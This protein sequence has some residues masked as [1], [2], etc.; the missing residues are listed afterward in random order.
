MIAE[1]VISDMKMGLDPKQYGNQ[2]NTSIQH[3]LLGLL[4]RIVTSV[5]KNSKGEIN[6]VL[7]SFVDWKSAFSKQC[8][9]LGI[10]SFLRN[11]VRPSLIPL[12]ISY[13]QNRQMRVKHHGKVSKSRKMPGSGAQGAT[14]GNWEF[15]SQTNNNSDCVPEE[16]RFKF[17]DDLTILEIINLINI[18]LSSYN[19]RDHVASDISIN[20]H[21]VDKEHLL[22][23][24]YINTIN[25]WTEKQKMEISSKKTKAMIINFTDN[26]QF[27]TRLQ[28][29]NRN[30]E[31]VDQMKILGTIVTNK[32]S[33]QENCSYLIQRVN[34][35]MLLLK[36]ALSFGA[37][38]EEM[39]HLW[40]I[41]CRSVLEQSAIVWSSSLNED[42][43]AD[44]ERT[45]K[46]FAKMVLK[47][48]YK[49][50]E[51]ALLELNLEKLEK[52]RSDLELTFAKKCIKNGKLSNL[53]Q[54]N[55]KKSVETRQNEK[56]KVNHANTQRM[57]KSAVIHM[58][59]L[60]NEDHKQNKT[61]EIRT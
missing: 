6:A 21:F 1:L 43:K 57:Q 50:Y 34:K 36:K 22:S 24:K 30:I 58:Q 10:E 42:S 37:T 8:H 45:Q 47:N 53:F 41:Y 48:K 29:H 60:L 33:W 23:Q 25:E 35:R 54:E 44:L 56:F 55:E 13:F 17:V 40:I 49:D 51:S 18:G 46:V 7:M 59:N 11:G 27:T 5:D 19:F 28:L 61:K 52:R 4:H 3:Y 9:K 2:K 20:S 39:V 31:V 38:R 32:L 12:L 15:L 26:Y 16:D 14:L